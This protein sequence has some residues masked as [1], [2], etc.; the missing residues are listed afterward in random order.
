[1]LHT[2]SLLVDNKF[3]VLA[4]ITGLIS[5]RGFNIESLA[6][7]PTE[8]PSKSRVTVV[9]DADEV[10][11]EQIAKQLHKLINVHK[12]NDFTNEA[13][14][15]R[16]LVL[17]KVHA[18]AESRHELIELVNVFRAKIVDIGKN[19]MTIEATGTSDKLA[20]MED[21]LRGYGIK[22]M[23]RTGKIALSRGN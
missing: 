23:A 7:G 18:P 4:R 2:L 11:L 15:D 21:L 8:D 6:V 12:I 22:E 14:V 16:E 9:V 17:F 19:S 3:G 20:A 5:R 10:S 13:S 1:M